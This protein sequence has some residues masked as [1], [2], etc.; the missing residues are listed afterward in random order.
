[1]GKPG[2]GTMA[3]VT[4]RAD[5]LWP[6]GRVPYV[7][8]A[9][10]G[11]VVRIDGKQLPPILAQAGAEAWRHAVECFTVHI[12]NPN[13]RAAYSRAVISFFR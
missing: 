10:P 5:A 3:F 2:E 6:E 11:D 7:I 13:T 1:M 4:S 9:G 8:T 12:R